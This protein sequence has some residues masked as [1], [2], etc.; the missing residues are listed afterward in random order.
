[1]TEKDTILQVD[2]PFE[3]RLQLLKSE[4]SRID[5]VWLTHPHSDH[6]AGIDDIRMASFKN[7]M[8][9][10]LFAG[11][12]TLECVQKRFPYMFFGNDYVDRPFLHPEIMDE[13]P[14]RFKDM[15]LIPIKHFHG[16][17]EVHSFRMNDFGLLADI[18]SISE[19]EL[20]K[21]KGVKILAVCTTVKNPHTR[22]MTFHEVID[23][24][25]KIS[26]QRAYLTHMNHTFD[27]DE[28]QSRL[29]EN[30]FPA[31]DGLRISF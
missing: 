14:F 7:N 28:T 21:L 31:Y 29:P 16:N 10:P 6:I 20:E 12:K 3:L 17:T 30:I 15:N 27:Y 4:V 25:K 11:K 1:M 13:K 23:L 22:H 8:P 19:S 18:S 9:L 5:A 24:I 26:P 2:L